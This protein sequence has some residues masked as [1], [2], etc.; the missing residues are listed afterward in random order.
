MT[1]TFNL[2]SINSQKIVRRDGRDSHP[3]ISRLENVNNLFDSFRH[4]LSKLKK[5]SLRVS[6]NTYMWFRNKSYELELVLQIN[7]N[8]I[9][10]V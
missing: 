3:I 5:L 7:V 4:T 8:I 10:I 1:K 2:N 9:Y 6:G